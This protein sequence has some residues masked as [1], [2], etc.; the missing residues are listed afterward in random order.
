VYNPPPFVSHIQGRES[1]KHWRRGATVRRSSTTPLMLDSMW[2][3]GGP[4]YDNK[5]AIQAP[6][7]NGHWRNYNYEMMHFAMDRHDGGVNAVFMDGSTRQVPI[8][9]LWVL[10]WHKTYRPRLG[11]AQVSSSWPAWMADY[12]EYPASDRVN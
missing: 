10:R 8:K 12:P 7:Y 9:Q 1:S 11:L 6:D 4:D 3:G 5:Y 2:R